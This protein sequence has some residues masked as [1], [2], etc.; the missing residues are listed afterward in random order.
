[1]GEGSAGTSAAEA[2][3]LA[4]VFNRDVA[5]FV[6]GLVHANQSSELQF[7]AVNLGCEQQP[8]LREFLSL[9]SAAAGL[10]PAPVLKPVERPKSFLPSVDRPLRLCCRRMNEIYGFSATPL[11]DVL[12]SCSDWF[13]DACKSFPEEAADAAMKLPVAARATALA[14]AGLKMPEPASSS[15]S[16]DSDS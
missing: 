12:K 5:R 16:S 8:T 3:P 14:S 9:L 10:G 13:R 11:E 6:A 15:S 7:D 2:P 4:F 1:D